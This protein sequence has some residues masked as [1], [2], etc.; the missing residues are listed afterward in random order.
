MPTISKIIDFWA[1][2]FAL[3]KLSWIAHCLG[4]EH[5]LVGPQLELFDR[6]L[7]IAIVKPGGQT[8]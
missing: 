2:T 8:L 5:A 3:I 7:L 1:G 6:V 4:E